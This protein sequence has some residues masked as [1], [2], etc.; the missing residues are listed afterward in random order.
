VNY[1][2]MEEKEYYTP[3]EVADIMGV[4]KNTVYAWIKNGF[5]PTL[6]VGGRKYRHRIHRLDIPAFARKKK[7]GGE[8]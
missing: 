2:Q 7:K 4:C 5:I 1:I 8:K 3:K 6:Q